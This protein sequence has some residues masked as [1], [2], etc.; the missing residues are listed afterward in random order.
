[1]RETMLMN[2]LLKALLLWL[3]IAALPVQGFPA[4]LPMHCA[5]SLQHVLAADDAAGHQHGV[6]MM[7]AQSGHA[8]AHASLAMDQS[9]AAHPHTGSFC[10]ACAACCISATALPAVAISTPVHGASQ[11]VVVSSTL[12]ATDYITAGLERPPRPLPP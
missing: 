7:Q 2:R 8:V 4:A 12:V 11:P 10:S 3:L 1:M 5:P 9:P 6:P